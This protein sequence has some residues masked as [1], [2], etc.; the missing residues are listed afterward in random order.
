MT[1][2]RRTLAL[3]SMTASLG[4]G[5]S[6]CKRPPPPDAPDQGSKPVH[7]ENGCPHCDCDLEPSTSCPAGDL[8]RLTE[9]DWSASEL[10]RMLKRSGEGTVA[11]DRSVEGTRL[12]PGCRLDGTYMEV[13]GE[14][15]GGRFWAT[16]RVM[17]RTSEIAG[18]CLSATHAL[19]AFAV[20]GLQ[21][22][23]LF[24]GA[25]EGAP[26]DGGGLRF[27]ALLVPLPCPPVGDEGKAKGCLGRGLAGPERERRALKLADASPKDGYDEDFAYHFEVYA[28]MPDERG[29]SYLGHGKRPLDCYLATQLERLTSHGPPSE[30]P[31]FLSDMGTDCQN[32]PPFLTCFPGLFDPAPGGTSCWKPV[33]R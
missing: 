15:G 10:G 3:A 4:V 33:T 12:V 30:W 18:E 5:T 8:P 29:I 21:R 13:Q 31:R 1:L 20:L 32:W 9:K 17:F 25:A 16:N 27:S 22:G 14:A 7:W 11:V 2:A 19:A 6:G 24:K 23:A 26:R 28:L